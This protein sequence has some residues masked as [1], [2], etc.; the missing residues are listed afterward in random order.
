MAFEAYKLIKAVERAEK[1]IDNFSEIAGVTAV[2][3]FT[4]NFRKQ[5]FDNNGVTPWKSRK[6]DRMGWNNAR[7]ILVKSGAL[8]RSLFRRSRGKL[9]VD[10]ISNLPYSKIQND[11]GE[12]NKEFNRKI[13][14]FNRDGKFTKTRTRKQRNA[15]SHQ[16]QVTINEH[17]INIPAR[18]FMGDSASLDKKIISR[19][20]TMIKK[21]FS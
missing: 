20:D 5:G 19:L 1:E 15:I 6:K 8:R 17:N 2:N 10:I 7:A 18:P 11:G 14:S 4:L 16:Q 9:V 21:A 3:H 13:L 12:I